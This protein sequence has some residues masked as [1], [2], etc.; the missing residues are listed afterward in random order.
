MAPPNQGGGGEPQGELATQI[1][2]DF[3]SFAA[4]KRAFEEAAMKHFGSGWVF[5]V[6]DPKT[7]KLE[8]VTLPNQDSVLLIGKP[9]LFANDLWEHAYYL[10]HRNMKAAYLAAWWDVANWPY[11]GERLT[12]IREGKK[13][14]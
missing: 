10:K 2:R 9:A 11:I 5:L 8:I 13:Q 6:V 3:G 14:L 1:D 4:M 7:E 12:G